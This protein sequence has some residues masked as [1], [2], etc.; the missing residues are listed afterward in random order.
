MIIYI[1]I[2]HVPIETDPTE[3]QLVH[4]TC[5]VSS[6]PSSYSK[7]ERNSNVGVSERAT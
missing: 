3:R 6:W 4:E 1:Y 7:N 2:P 5:Y